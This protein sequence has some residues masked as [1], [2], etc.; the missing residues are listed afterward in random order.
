MTY[1]DGLTGRYSV[2]ANTTNSNNINE[3]ETLGHIIYLYTDNENGIQENTDLNLKLKYYKDSNVWKIG[4]FNVIQ[5]NRDVGN[6]SFPFAGS[7]EYTDDELKEYEL[8]TKDLDYVSLRIT[9]NMKDLE[10]K[11]PIDTRKKYFIYSVKVVNRITQYHFWKYFKYFQNEQNQNLLKGDLYSDYW[12]DNTKDST[13][14]HRIVQFSFKK[15]DLPD[16][17]TQQ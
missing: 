3:N 5:F 17:S 14:D 4:L 9:S 1:G 16:L 12:D 8:T 6:V 15:R 10:S 2:Y 11:I 7:D 13:E